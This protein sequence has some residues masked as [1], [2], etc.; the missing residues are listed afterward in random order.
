MYLKM[1]WFILATVQL[2][3]AN[4]YSGTPD[5]EIIK[6]HSYCEVK[7]DK[8]INVD[9]FL[10][11]INNRTGEKYTEIELPYS[12]SD[13]ISGIEARLEDIYGNV[14]RTLK[15]R[16]IVDKNEMSEDIMYSDRYLKTFQLK[17]N[18]Y[19]YRIFYTYKTTIKKFNIIARW[20]PQ[21]FSEV[22][23]NDARLY[24]KL[25]GNFAVKKYI[26]GA[27][28][29]NSLES[30]EGTIEEYLSSCNKTE[31]NEKFA[32]PYSNN[33]PLVL[34]VPLNFNY[35]V[36]GSTE[37]W[38]TFGDWYYNLNK[39]LNDLSIE[40]RNSVQKLISG[41]TDKK[42][43]IKTLYHYMQD[44]TRYINVSIGVGGL[45]AFPASYVSQNKYGDCKALTNYMK[46]LLEVAGIKSYYTLINTGNQPENLIEEIPCPQ[47][48]HIILT[49]PINNDTIWLENTS[50]TCPF[51]YVGTSIQNR[52]ALLIDENNS[53]FINMPVMRKEDVLVSSKMVID[54]LTDACATA[55]VVNYF[56]GHSFENF[57][58]FDSYA[59]KDIQ[60]KIIRDIM[61]LNNSEVSKWEIKKA[62]RD[63]FYIELKMKINLFKFLKPLGN[64]A[65]FSL[66]SSKYLDF[67]PP[68]SRTVSLF[69]SY[70]VFT[71]DS[72]FYSIPDNYTVK[73][74]PEPYK[75]SDKFGNY[76]LTFMTSSNDIVVVRK[77]EIFPARYDID[78]Y[79][80]FFKFINS[81]KESERKKIVLTRQNHSSINK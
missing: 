10:I 66:F 65:Y 30:S 45:K 38:K 3:F 49:V 64:D 56:K 75:I 28:L 40:D 47:F 25:P 81:V 59:N 42:E 23:T 61:P 78:Q 76:E 6:Y 39:D 19:P 9:S 26:R 22:P 5:C 57:N 33:I 4:T 46:S 70:P 63:S 48:N 72:F 51:G 77:L 41:I 74:I 13:K 53:R 21:I 54:F 79:T 11:Q 52:K 80:D 62:N 18:N 12:K 36:N 50:T 8:L 29:E 20:T 71:I 55:N 24:I 32:E 43:I 2:I 44:H 67:E 58:D 7:I 17:H 31:T 27:T 73:S 15:R 16:E 1:K 68:V 69:F 14:I 60:D 34:M 37:S 35:D